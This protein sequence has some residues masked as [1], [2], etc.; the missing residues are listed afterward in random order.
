MSKNPKTSIVKSGFSITI[1]SDL[2]RWV[3]DVVKSKRFA[4]R[5]HGIEY[6]LHELKKKS[7]FKVQ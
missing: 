2:V 5:S 4:S 6:A 7:E 3:D 1:D